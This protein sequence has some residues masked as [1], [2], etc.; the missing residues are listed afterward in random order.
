MQISSAEAIRFQQ[1]HIQ[2][3]N[4]V[5]ATLAAGRIAA[6]IGARHGLTLERL[7]HARIE[8]IVSTLGEYAERTGDG[9]AGS[10]H[11]TPLPER[12][13][14][15]VLTNDAPSVDLSE[16]ANHAL[17]GFNAER[18]KPDVS[19]LVHL[20]HNSKGARMLVSTVVDELDT[21]ISDLSSEPT[22]E[23]VVID[24]GTVTE[25]VFLPASAI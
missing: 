18:D 17:K 2:P 15:A 10:T 16:R 23:R 12:S 22:M 5:L 9:G 6:R 4:M 1:S 8:Q 7:R 13:A 21:L 11:F 20:L 3:E 24:K 19:L 25:Q 14:V